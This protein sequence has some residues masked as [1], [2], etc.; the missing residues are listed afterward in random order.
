M[1]IKV[2]VNY[3]SDAILRALFQRSDQ[4][5]LTVPQLTALY[6]ASQLK[7][8]ANRASNRFFD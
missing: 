2:N 6:R 7:A 8:T 4:P 1:A 5:R 3:P